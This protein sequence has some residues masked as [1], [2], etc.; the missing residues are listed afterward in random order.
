MSIA[1]NNTI[2]LPFAVMQCP[3]LGVTT[4]AM[5]AAVCNCGGIGSLPL[6][7]TTAEQ[8][9]QLIIE[10]KRLTDKPFIVN[11]FLHPLV[12]LQE[13]NYIET[14]KKVQKLTQSIG[15]D[16]EIQNQLS[17]VSY[18]EL[19]PVLF[20]HQIELVAFTFGCF[21]IEEINLLH[22]NKCTLIGTATTIPE[23]KYLAKQGIDI[24]LLQGIEAG[25]HR[26][27]F[28]EDGY[29]NQ[30]PLKE[31]F[32]AAKAL[33]LDVPYLVA[34][35][36]KDGADG[37]MYL[38]EGALLVGY[39]SIY[40]A[41]DESA[42]PSFQK[43]ILAQGIAVDTV[44]TKAF[45]GKWARGIKNDFMQKYEALERNIPPFPIQNLFT[46]KMRSFAKENNLP[47]YYSM[48]SGVNGHYARKKETKEIFNQLI[49]EIYE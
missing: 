5:V 30:L 14:Q 19:L 32:H 3:M 49:H 15:F 21:T 10:T 28:L 43:D 37:K 45:S 8:A 7:G 35:G 38:S 12:E 18:K 29:T 11:L 33:K 22:Q 44:F 36:L 46:G 41:S 40:L 24:I 47:D 16:Y 23:V 31:L 2:K 25:G 1:L 4:P 13:D 42:A 48:W 17:Q 9:N 39:G 27:S 6:G 20:E 26:G 34:G